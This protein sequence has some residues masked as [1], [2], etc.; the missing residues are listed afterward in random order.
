MKDLLEAAHRSGRFAGSETVE[1]AGDPELVDVH[2]ETLT[3]NLYLV[4]LPPR[5]DVARVLFEDYVFD[6]V[7][8][9]RILDF[10]DVLERG[11]VRFSFAWFGRELVLRVP[12]PEGTWVDQRR[13]RGD[14]S[15]WEK[16]VF[17]QR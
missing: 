12:L 2:L 13:F 11:E 15:D 5:L 16:G 9:H 8:A 17:E 10:V 6:D 3:G 14:L 4:M 1:V 7:P